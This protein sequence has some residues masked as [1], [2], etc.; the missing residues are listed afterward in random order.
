MDGGSSPMDGFMR[1]PETGGREK[2]PSA[3]SKEAAWACGSVFG[4]GQLPVRDPRPCQLS[5]QASVRRAVN[6][7]G[8]APDTAFQRFGAAMQRQG[9]LEA[10]VS[11]RKKGHVEVRPRKHRVAQLAVRKL[12]MRARRLL[13]LILSRRPI[14]SE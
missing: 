14:G 2:A 5:F 13:A 1:L 7:S 6:G 9:Q 12:R 3:R 8:E 10:V 4:G 11:H